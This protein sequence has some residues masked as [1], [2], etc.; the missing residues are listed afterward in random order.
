MIR[1]RTGVLIAT[2]MATLGSASLAATQRVELFGMAFVSADVTLDVGDTIHWVWVTGFHNVESGT[3]AAGIG[4]PDGNF[5]SGNPTSGVTFDLVFDQAMLDANPM[6][7]NIYVYYCVVHAGSNMAGTITVI[8]AGDLDRD[9]DVDVEDQRI[10]TTCMAGPGTDAPPAGCSQEQ[11][12]HADA[13]EDGDV[14]LLDLAVIQRA[15][16]R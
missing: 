13:D 11:M 2:C 5:R 9:T 12:D 15:F 1:G 8:V 16:T 4:V 7:G 6:P 14:D 10:A 3:I